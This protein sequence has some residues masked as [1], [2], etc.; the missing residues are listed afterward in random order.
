MKAQ[1]FYDKIP[2]TVLEELIRNKLFNRSGTVRNTRRNITS[3]P[4]TRETTRCEEVKSSQDESEGHDSSCWRFPI[5]NQ[6][7]LG[8]KYLFEDGR[9]VSI[10]I[11]YQGFE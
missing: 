8:D 5:Q 3:T 2:A 9:Q 6:T 11:R 1:E 7:P 10:D 4:S